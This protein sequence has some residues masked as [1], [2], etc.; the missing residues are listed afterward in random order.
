MNLKLKGKHAA[1]LLGLSSVLVNCGAKVAG[2]GTDT[3]TDW[4][5]KCEVDNECDPDKLCGCG[6]CTRECTVDADC[7]ALSSGAVCA[8]STDACDRQQTICVPNTSFSWI[9]EPAPTSS[10]TPSACAEFTG[11]VK[12]PAPRQTTFQR[13]E[14]VEHVN[15]VPLVDDTAL[16][17]FD[18]DRKLYALALEGVGP[19]QSLMRRELVPAAA[20]PQTLTG[21]LMSNDST[22]FWT[23]TDTPPAGGLPEPIL[24][25]PPSRL[26][27]VAKTGGPADLLYESTT[28]VLR[29]VGARSDLLLLASDQSFEPVLAFSLSDKTLRAIQPELASTFD[30]ASDT[31]LYWRL[32]TSESNEVF[33][34]YRTGFDGKDAER[35]ATDVRGELRV[36][37]DYAVWQHERLVVEP[38]LV[39][40]QNFVV[41]H[42]DTQCAARPLPGV[43]ESISSFSVDGSHVYW[44]SYNALGSSDVSQGSSLGRSPILRAN[45]S[46]GELEE[47]IIPGFHAETTVDHLVAQTDKLLFVYGSAGLV[48]IDKPVGTELPECW[49]GPDNLLGM[50]K[51]SATQRVDCG[52]FNALE[53]ERVTDA[54]NCLE[55][56]PVDVG[57]QVAINNCVDCLALSIFI[58]AGTPVGTQE[59]LSAPQ[60]SF[61][62]TMAETAGQRSVKVERCDSFEQVEGTIRCVH[63]MLEHTCGG[64]SD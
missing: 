59:G 55:A 20:T 25:V 18:R 60:G 10:S 48:A 44:N 39:L 27:G 51:V 15:S 26:Y 6:L 36:V 58:H 3:S 4:V 54:F 29:L 30:H 53:S 22:V 1:L 61:H 16:Y 40:D 2:P 62:I 64:G 28:Q 49:W 32:A 42:L 37:D 35:V 13:V 63:P 52:G 57:A 21:P 43:G 50:V 7:A 31:D 38:T 17:W 47:L 12:L 56:A 5:E 45:L 24:L 23:E 34:L 9:T 41:Q 11:G 14:Q 8:H 19:V 46:T 33:D